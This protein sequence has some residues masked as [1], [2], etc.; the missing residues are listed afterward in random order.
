LALGW[1]G[2]R[3]FDWGVDD[4]LHHCVEESRGGRTFENNTPNPVI[5]DEA[6]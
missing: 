1:F 5:Y 3:A 4:V 6:A 2:L